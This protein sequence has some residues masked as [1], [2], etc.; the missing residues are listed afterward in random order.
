MADYIRAHFPIIH[1]VINYVFDYLIC[2][3]TVSRSCER[4]LL[5]AVGVPL[6][7]EFSDENRG[8]KEMQNNRSGS[9]QGAS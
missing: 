1:F 5:S 8:D 2:L 3:L 4:F 9:Y 7:P 6:G